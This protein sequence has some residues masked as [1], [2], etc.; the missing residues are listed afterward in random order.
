VPQLRQST[1]F[2]SGCAGGLRNVSTCS[3]R[4][5][6]RRSEFRRVKSSKLHESVSCICRSPLQS[7]G[8]FGKSRVASTKAIASLQKALSLKPRLH[9]ANLFSAWH[10]TAAIVSRW[11]LRRSTGNCRVSQRWLSLDVARHH[12]S[13]PWIVPKKQ[14]SSLDKAASLTPD[15]VDILYQPRPAHLQVSKNSFEKM[16]K[17][18]PKSWRVHQVLAQANSEADRPS[19]AIA[20]YQEAIKLAPAQPGL[21]EELGSELRSAGK[22]PRSGGRISTRTGN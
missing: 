1:D 13:W 22:T 12:F 20:E 2:G 9:G 15:N 11:R 18:D 6:A 21:H 16:L 17:A 5:A 14:P 8:W 19:D 7:G 10:T 3:G 4:H